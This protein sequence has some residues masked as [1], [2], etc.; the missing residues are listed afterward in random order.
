MRILVVGGGGREHAIVWKLAQSPRVEHI[1]CAPGNAGIASL[2][3]CVPI[4][5]KDIGGMVAF[6]RANH[7]DL[8]FV[9]PDDPLALGMVDAME[10]A[11][12]RA[13][14]PRRNAAILEASKI[15]S[16]G[17]MKRY[18]IPTAG[19]EVFD[20]P[21][22]A[23]AYLATHPA[24]IVVKADGLALGKGVVVARTTQEAED[25]VRAMMGAQ[26]FGEAGSRIV[27]EEFLEGP[28]LTVLAFT[29]GRTILP[30]VSSRDHKRAL[31]GDEG[32]NTGGMGAVSPGADLSPETE[33]YLMDAIL[34][35]TV[36]AMR[37]EGRLFQGV[38]YFGLMLTKEG[39]KVI[40][41]N[42]RFGDPETQAVLP[43][44]ETDLLDIVEAVIDRRLH[45]LTLRW[46]PAVTCCVVLAS[47]GYPGHYETG[48]PISGIEEAAALPDT[49]VFHAGTRFAEGVHLE[50]RIAMG[51]PETR[52]PHGR[53]GQA[54]YETAGGRVLGVTALADELETAILRAYDGAS[55]IS[56]P[57]MHFRKDIG[58]TAG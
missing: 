41:Y 28:E 34:Q 37:K 40:E 45:E 7:P 14:G 50:K 17:L 11:G 56:F 8:V 1:W 23:L 49:L 57:Q 26:L 42:A 29:D 39:P 38:L 10:A 25:A 47:G 33:K 43:R 27:V 5:A 21:G 44:L 13:F 9:A 15:F 58:R 22:P 18:G 30:M 46:S 36:D 20:A 54:V 31:D 2:A 53:I 32:P 3:E 35:P 48:L 55:R 24:P 6:A 16:K 19:Y 12:F 52:I 51:R 4:A